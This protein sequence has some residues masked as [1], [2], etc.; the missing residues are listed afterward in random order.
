M[1]CPSRFGAGWIPGM[2]PRIARRLLLVLVP[3]LV[4]PACGS[5][6]VDVVGRA[7]ASDSPTASATTSSPT[8]VPVTSAPVSEKPVVV[9]QPDGLGFLVGSSSIRQLPFGGPAA[10][11]I[12]AVEAAL[13]K[14]K[15][16]ELPDCGQ[17]A[18]AG[19]RV[20]GLS[21]LL[22]GATFV[23]W[24]E[25]GDSATRLTTADG[26]GVGT[27]RKDLEAAF[28]KLE[29]VESTLGVEWGVGV[30]EGLTGFLDA[31]TPA[32]KVTQLAGGETCYFR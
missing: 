17:G 26:I 9:L 28:P 29:V 31:D 27:S 19:Y 22:D 16:T 5:N 30:D 32:A 4:L 20:G 2:T 14:G 18:R 23:G 15:R 3:L 11:V 24:T 21:L 10:P 13:G 1:G 8:A 7:D 6:D 25:D 12:T